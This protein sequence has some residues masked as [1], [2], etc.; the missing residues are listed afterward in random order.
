M[1]KKIRYKVSKNICIVLAFCMALVF[2]SCGENKQ[3]NS[4]SSEPLTMYIG[5]GNT[6]GDYYSKLHDAILENTG[7]DVKMI[8]SNTNDT[9]NAMASRIKHYDLPADIMITAQK[10]AAESQVESFLDLAKYTN[11]PDLFRVSTLSEFSI[12]GAV[13]QLPFTTRL[14]GIEYNKTLLEEHGWDLPNNFD[15]MVALKKL[16]DE[17]GVTFA[18]SGGFATGHGFNYLFHIMGSDY[19]TSPDGTQWLKDFRAGKVG[20]EQFEAEAE[21]FKKYAEAG[22]FGIIHDE[23]WNANTRFNNER[24]LFY[25]N[26][27]NDA[28]QNENGDEYGSMP[29]IQEDGMSNCFTSY[30]S[31]FVA[32][33]KKLA[34]SS[35]QT[36]LN[37]AIK[38]LE[39]MSGEEAIKLF[40]SVFPDGYVATSSFEI[41]ETRLYYDYIDSIKQ[42]F[43]QP[44]YYNEFDSDTIVNVGQKVNDYL[45]GKNNT[46]F[47]DIINELEIQNQLYLEG[48]IDT[49]IHITTEFDYEDCAK[50]Q[51]KANAMSLQEKLDE[52]IPGLEVAV[53]LMPYTDDLAKL[54][55][56]KSVGVVQEKI[57]KDKYAFSESSRIINGKSAKPVAVYMTGAE[58]TNLVN[59]GYDITK[60]F[61]LSETTVFPYAMAI[62][63]GIT[64]RDD[65]TYIV[66]ISQGSI[67][68]TLYN[69]YLDEG[70]ILL[71]ENGNAITANMEIGLGKI[72]ETYGSLS[73]SITI[74]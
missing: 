18:V 38:V 34:D 41:D 23:N 53:S 3:N 45:S 50:F 72:F 73:P 70:K 16:A 69:Q 26:I 44:W 14:I 5:L 33:D 55:L 49:Y 56:R 22:L 68:S 9:S 8:Y 66:A 54:P 28:Y 47:E 31:M 2:S 46:S 17:A 35:Q 62:R 60:D 61:E 63:N 51:A 1:N 67:E 40:T 58:I 7:I 71:D 12:N 42:G 39:Y 30:D 57:Y 19:L 21:Y 10:T 4:E 64:L 65:Q 43:I 48:K 11:I 52:T 74:W 13:Y 27:L 15:E 29:W 37:D 59:K 24:A 32:L 20:I 25:Y 36:R 6:N